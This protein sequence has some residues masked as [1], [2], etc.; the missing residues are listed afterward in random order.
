[1]GEWG[2]GLIRVDLRTGISKQDDL[3][4]GVADLEVDRQ[5]RVW[6][7]GGIAHLLVREGHLRR[8]DEDAW[9]VVLRI[10]NEPRYSWSKSWGWPFPAEP[11]QAVAFDAAGI[12][13]VLT[14]GLGVVRYDAGVWTHLTRFWPQ[15]AT[16]HLETLVIAPDSTL[17]IGTKGAG[18]LLWK[19]GE[20]T[21]R[22]VRLN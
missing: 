20:A 22:Q 17:V 6:A 13:Y 5:G 14:Q 15:R 19:P 11:I 12:P 9:A 16:T 8:L 1:V 4:F 18:V 7:A 3:G 21:L 10:T 2:G